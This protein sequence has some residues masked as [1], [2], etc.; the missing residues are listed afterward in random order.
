MTGEPRA[1]EPH[2]QRVE[3]LFREHNE[4]LLRYL[5]VRLHSPDEAKEVAQEA[6]VQLLGLHHPET[7]HFL[8]AY[9]FQTAGNLAKDRLKQ[10]VRRRRIDELVFFDPG[11]EDSRSPER[12]WAAGRDLA[13]IRRALQELPANCRLAFNLVKF[14]GLSIDEAAHELDLHPRRVRRYVARA[15]EHCLVML[16]TGTTPGGPR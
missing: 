8:Q 10:R 1:S 11:L 16:E 14:D 13:A 9:L 12:A 15:L 4:S 6:Y 3:R 2:A 5:R 7:I